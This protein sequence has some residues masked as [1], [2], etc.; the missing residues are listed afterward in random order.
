MSGARLSNSSRALPKQRE[1]CHVIGH[2]GEYW[3]TK[4]GEQGPV[5]T[6]SFLQ[7]V[8]QLALQRQAEGIGGPTWMPG[9]LMAF[10]KR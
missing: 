3:P 9:N 7:H 4:L 8:S 2:S 6:S 10:R 5:A 1:C